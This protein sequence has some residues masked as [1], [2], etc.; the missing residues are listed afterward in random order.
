MFREWKIENAPK[1][2]KRKKKKETKKRNKKAKRKQKP[3]NKNKPH[4]YPNLTKCNCKTTI[5]IECVTPVSLL[6]TPRLCSW[7]HWWIKL[8]QKNKT[9]FFFL[10]HFLF[11]CASPEFLNV[12]LFSPSVQIVRSREN[13]ASL[14]HVYHYLHYRDCQLRFACVSD[15]C[16]EIYCS[17]QVRSSTLELEGVVIVCCLQLAT[18]DQSSDSWAGMAGMARS[19]SAKEGMRGVLALLPGGWTAIHNKYL[20]PTAQVDYDQKVRGVNWRYS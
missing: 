13:D 20:A 10:F 14:W 18:G 4:L 12:L 7:C 3:K 15:L 19:V 17:T 16:P 1:K 11:L 2:R 9:P 5:N 8:K 6:E